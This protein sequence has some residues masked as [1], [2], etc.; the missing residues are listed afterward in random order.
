MFEIH[1][2]YKETLYN[3]VREPRHAVTSMEDINA[4][5]SYKPD[6]SLHKP[7]IIDV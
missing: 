3:I 5:S 7:A 4:F 6:D 1:I 2:R